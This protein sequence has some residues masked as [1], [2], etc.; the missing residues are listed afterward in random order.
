M[1]HDTGKTHTTLV[2]DN[3][4][5]HA[6]IWL[7]IATNTVANGTKTSTLATKFSPLVANLAS[8]FLRKKRINK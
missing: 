4:C 3:H 6:H 5:A 1:K 8:S 7:E 2:V